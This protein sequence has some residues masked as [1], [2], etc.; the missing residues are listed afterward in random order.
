MRLRIKGDFAK[1]R[2]LR[3][4]LGPSGIKQLKRDILENVAEEILGFTKQ[5][6]RDERDPY[7]RRWAPKKKPDGRKVLSGKTSRLKKW[8]VKKRSLRG[9]TIAPTVT[10]AAFHQDGTRHMP[11]RMIVP[12]EA[13][14]L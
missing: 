5:R 13:K 7:G 4:K 8:Q 11:R 14:G 3:K 6:F 10:Y 9:F 1:L 12:D 2:R